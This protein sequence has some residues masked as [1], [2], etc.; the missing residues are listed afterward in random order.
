MQKLIILFLIFLYPAFSK[1]QLAFQRKD[2]FISLGAS[3]VDYRYN[4]LLNSEKAGKSLPVFISTE[5]GINNRFS[6]GPFGGYYFRKYRHIGNFST[7]TTDEFV[8]KSHYTVLGV[9]GTFHFTEALEKKFDTYLYSEDLDLYVSLLLG[10]EFNGFTRMNGIS[11]KDESKP[12]VGV[13]V[14]ARYFLN[15]RIALFGEIGPGIFGLA[16]VGLTARF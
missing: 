10:Y 2:L 9:R 16:S 12:V 8:Y 11:I 4:R 14:G 1:A 6:L 5:Y 13:V 15:Y 7:D 3:G